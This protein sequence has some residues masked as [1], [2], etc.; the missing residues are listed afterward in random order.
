MRLAEVSTP[1]QDQ[2]SDVAEKNKLKGEK[3][4]AL[5]KEEN[6]SLVKKYGKSAADT[7][8]AEVQVAILTQRIK[9]L[10]EHLKKNHGDNAARRSLFILVGKRR[11]LLKY[12]AD[13]DK[14]AYANLIASLGIRK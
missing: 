2:A 9:D 12:L 1:L 3:T 14:E 10:T 11:S 7:G 6:A 5:T 8:S 4:M 13:N